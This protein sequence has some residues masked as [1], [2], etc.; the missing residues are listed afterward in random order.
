MTVHDAKTPASRK[1]LQQKRHAW[2]HAMLRDLKKRNS[3]INHTAF[4]GASGSGK[5]YLADWISEIGI[6]AGLIKLFLINVTDPARL[7]EALSYMFWNEEGIKRKPQ[8][9]LLSGA[10]LNNPGLR[11]HSYKVRV[12]IPVSENA[13]NKLPD[14]FVPFTIP[15][16]DFSDRELKLLYGMQEISSVRSEYLTAI[17]TMSKSDGFGQL[18]DRLKEHTSKSHSY[19]SRSFQGAK[20]L[21]FASGTMRQSADSF[22]H[23][24]NMLN[25]EGLLSS[26]NFPFNLK[27]QLEKEIQDQKTIVILYTYYLRSEIMRYFCMLY[28]LKCLQDLMFKKQYRE[29][30]DYKLVVR[31]DE[32][33]FLI[34]KERSKAFAEHHYALQDLFH[35]ILREGR[36]GN[37]ESQI[38]SQSPTFLSEDIYTNVRSVYFCRSESEEDIEWLAT[39]GNLRKDLLNNV[40]RQWKLLADLKRE[41]RFAIPSI[42][43]EHLDAIPA[44]FYSG[45]R[46]F[47]FGFRVPRPRLSYYGNDGKVPFVQDWDKLIGLIV[48]K[49]GVKYELSTKMKQAKMLLK[50]EIEESYKPLIE[51]RQKHL[52]YIEEKTKE[53]MESEKE[54]AKKALELLKMGLSYREIS[55]IMGH[56]TDKTMQLLGY[57]V[58]LGLVSEAE[59]FDLMQKNK[60]R[61]KKVQEE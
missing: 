4:H 9:Y 54:N 41:Y 33:G 26:E 6:D 28:F 18:V 42:A 39:R 45:T 34:P 16:T 24:I 7:S 14:F 11:P 10:D 29:K 31:F 23:R 43:Q 40:M 5:T 35:F 3:D 22:I 37:I 50:E 32:A 38:I 53:K 20:V 55:G 57:A 13:P 25:Q 19:V 52:E 60:L 15:L 30:L 46:K 49:T 17:K 58:R 21:M 1:Y 56:S 8:E 59:M 36:H 12:Y 44:W 27:Q 51:K 48:E 47:E 61:R 2:V